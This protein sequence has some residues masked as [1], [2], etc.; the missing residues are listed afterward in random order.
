MSERIHI[1]IHTIIFAFTPFPSP[2]CFPQKRPRYETGEAEKPST[3][4][5]HPT[6]AGSHVTL[7][8]QRLAEEQTRRAAIAA[9]IPPPSA[10]AVAAPD[11]PRKSTAAERDRQ[12][13]AFITAARARDAEGIA[14]RLE[15]MR[16]AAPAGEKEP[17]WRA[18]PLLVP[19]P[20]A[21]YETAQGEE[22]IHK[23]ALALDSELDPYFYSDAAA[24][25]APDP[26]PA[27]PLLPEDFEPRTR[28]DALGLGAGSGPREG[29]GRRPVPTI[30][31]EPVDPV[32]RARLREEI[33]LGS[34]SM[35]HGLGSARSFYY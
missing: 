17:A 35:G 12:R 30:P 9:G 27:S 19:D 23:M 31:W 11:G 2:L 16:P 28:E 5:A 10:A 22:S 20:V 4:A 24:G 26:V 33:G 8:R 25:G 7:A 1:Y 3:S 29:R 13:Q 34:G 32:E 6:H 14:E 21:A 15:R 18:P